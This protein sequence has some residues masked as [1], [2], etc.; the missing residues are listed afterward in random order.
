MTAHAGTRPFIE[1]PVKDRTHAV[2]EFDAQRRSRVPRSGPSKRAWHPAGP[3]HSQGVL[4]GMPA[5]R[6]RH[7]PMW[8]MGARRLKL[9][10]SSARIA[11]YGKRHDGSRSCSRDGKKTATLEL[12]AMPE[13]RRA[14][15]RFAT[16][17]IL[18]ALRKAGAE[19]LRTTAEQS[20]IEREELSMTQ[21][22]ISTSFDDEEMKTLKAAVAHYLEVCQR[23]IDK[24][25]TAPFYAHTIVLTRSPMIRKMLRKRSSNLSLGESEV[26]ALKTALASYLEVCEREIAGG[27]TVPFMADRTMAMMISARLSDELTRAI[28]DVEEVRALRRKPGQ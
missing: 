11:L 16:A 5:R 6:G 17:F 27:D 28:M 13:D 15:S 2:R 20:A 23:E 19:A 7:L 22:G 24:G 14:R 25:A 18:L 21:Y 10:V 9:P 26:S 1:I 12:S 8:A 4:D 3:E